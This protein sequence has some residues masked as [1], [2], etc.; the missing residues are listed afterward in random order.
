MSVRARYAPSPTGSPH[1]G[2]LRTAI[3]SWLL[4]QKEG[5]A[6]IARLE[7]TDR[8]PERYV[9][10]GI[11]DIEASLRFLGILPDE[12]WVGGG[13]CGP[14]IQSERLPL[15][16]A[17]AE[18]LIESGKAY[19]C[20]CTRERLE[21]VRAV[22]QADKAQTGYDRHCRDTDRRE[23]MRNTRWEREGSE[24][25]HVVRLAMPLDG[26]TVLH[27]EDRKSTRLN[28]SHSS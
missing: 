25:P 18:R 6:F 13:P 22:Q 4:V 5:G 20:Y 11:Y 2:N 24:P 1:V 15:Y 14:Y 27:D 26:A 16:Q 10:E 12:W 23:Q 7:D 28:S 17:A 8:S 9:P 19:R 3:Y 21:A